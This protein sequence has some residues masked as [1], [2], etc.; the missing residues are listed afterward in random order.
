MSK[1]RKAIEALE[2][3]RPYLREL[4]QDQSVY[5]FFHGGDPRDFHPDGEASTEEERAAHKAACEQ[6]ERD[7]VG[8]PSCCEHRD[9]MIITKA[10]FGL[11]VNTYRDEEAV[12]AL[13]IVEKALS[14]AGE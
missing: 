6:F 12:K 7:A 2:S 4:A 14:E 13:A 8:S 1:Y 3:I 5:G 9:N 10:P 11:G